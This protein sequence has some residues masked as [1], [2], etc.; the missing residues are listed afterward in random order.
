MP[1]WLTQADLL[2]HLELPTTPAPT[3]GS[4]LEV[5]LA[6]AINAAVELVEERAQE[7]EW[8]AEDVPKVVRS[9]TLIQ[10]ERL[11]KRSAA[12]LGIATVNTVDGGTGMRITARLDP[13]V[14]VLLEDWLRSD[15]STL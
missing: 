11:F 10:A 1:G 9:A 4:Q 14:D 7:F 3:E 15:Y 2:A 12:P 6:D 13:D 8:S 5:R